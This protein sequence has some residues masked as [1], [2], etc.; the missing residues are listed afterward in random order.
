MSGYVASKTNINDI[1]FG[2]DIARK[3]KAG[4]DDMKKKLM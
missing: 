2:K 3:R 1:K 4:R